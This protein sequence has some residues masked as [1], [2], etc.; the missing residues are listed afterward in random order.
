MIASVVRLLL[1]NACVACG[2]AVESRT[3]DALVCA[4]CTSR[5]E[6]VRPGCSRCAQPLPPIGACRFCADWPPALREVRSA[7][8]L[9]AA[10]RA[11]AHHL[12]YDD[13]RSLADAMARVMR[14]E[15]PRPDAGVLVPIPVSPRKLRLRGYNQA[16]LIAV[17]LGKLWDLPVREDLLRRAKDTGT[18]TALTADARLAN[19]AAA[20][21]AQ[22]PAPGLPVPVI[23]VDDV[24]TTGATLR[25]AA[26]ALQA[27]EWEH[28]T[29]VTFARALTYDRRALANQ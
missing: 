22:R 15:L 7:A 10:A 28:I 8:W 18:Q 3:P 21:A 1:P 14:R 5:L 9:T 6:P 11:M 2:R 12:K 24:L 19:V 17:E 23:I 13:Y 20:F 29:A 26:S 16:A 4:V 27:A 25:A